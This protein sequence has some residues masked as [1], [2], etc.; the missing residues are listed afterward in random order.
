[1]ILFSCLA[2]TMVVLLAVHH[3]ATC[4][5]KAKLGAAQV[6]K[7]ASELASVMG[8]SDVEVLL[9]ELATRL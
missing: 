9:A 8:S 5:T 4:I 7:E 3:N 6:L 1:M 2:Y